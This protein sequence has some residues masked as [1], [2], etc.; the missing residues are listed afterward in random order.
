MLGTTAKFYVAPNGTLRILNV[1]YEDA[2]PY[3][4][5][6]STSRGYTEWTVH[7]GVIAPQ[8]A[9]TRASAFHVVEESEGAHVA[10]ESCKL[11][12]DDGR[13]CRFSSSEEGD[14]DDYDRVYAPPTIRWYFNPTK[15]ECLIFR[16][17]GCGGNANRF[18]TT[19]ECWSR[20]RPDVNVCTYDRG[21]CSQ[22]CV[23]EDGRARC[24]CH[25]SGYK[26]GEDGKQCI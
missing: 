18:K 26:L 22:S 21:D 8:S 25:H 13:L 17:D 11:P 15:F 20:C 10:N 16:Y 5:E 12:K 19:A 7:L 2:G 9:A 4:C 3:T 6:K 23:Y 24:E 14:Y 1:V